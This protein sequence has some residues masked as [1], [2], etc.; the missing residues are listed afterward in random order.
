LKLTVVQVNGRIF[1]DHDMT[2]NFNPDSVFP[3]VRWTT[4]EHAHAS[5]DTSTPETPFM[6]NINDGYR[7]V[8]R[9]SAEG[10]TDQ[11]ALLCPSTVRR[12]SLEDK[13]W[14]EFDIEKAQDIEWDLDCFPKLQFN[15][16]IR[17]N[18]KDLM[19]QHHATSDDFQDVV[20]GKGKGLILLL[21]GPPG[22]GKTLTAG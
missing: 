5:K 7:K 22:S 4:Q 2:L 16:S 12:Y 11:Q 13:C 8:R 21:Y 18:L 6:V 3:L 17:E 10:Q 14:M 15:P 20:A 9:Q 19:T 1:L